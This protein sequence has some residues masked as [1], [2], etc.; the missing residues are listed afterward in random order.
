[1]LLNGKEI[2]DANEIAELA[3]YSYG[4]Y[5]TLLITDA[6]V[7]G[8]HFHIER[9]L[10]DAQALFTARPS[11]N[12]ILA[13]L[14]AFVG[15]P[16]IAFTSV[17]R[18]TVFPK[19][20]SFTRPEV[21]ND[22]NILISGRPAPSVIRT[23]LQIKLQPAR[24]SLPK[25]KTTTF[26]ECL[27]ARA[28]ARNS[29]YDDALLVI[30]H[31]ITEGSFWNVFFTKGAQIITPSADGS[32]LPGVTRRII[33]EL[34]QQNSISLLE[35]VISVDDLSA[36]DGCFATNAAFGVFPI[37]AID[38]IKFQNCENFR[39]VIALYAQYP[40]TSIP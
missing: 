39:K 28:L 24:R 17:V 36:F 15:R 30:D 13:Q 9:L 19:Q 26:L 32:I 1:M 18:I 6:G 21:V 14:K 33:F 3:L 11:T 4:N 40:A 7:K 16:N 25:L 20:F 5:T 35:S 27:Q 23:P 31:Q 22:F 10:N 34:C 37:G 38:G 8:L 2:S 12:K 29:G